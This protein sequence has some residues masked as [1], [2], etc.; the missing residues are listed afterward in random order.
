MPENQAKLDDSLAQHYLAGFTFLR[1]HARTNWWEHGQLAPLAIA[2]A[3]LYVSK[4][5][6]TL[7]LAGTPF[8][9]VA[10]DPELVL[11]DNYR[12]PS[13]REISDGVQRTREL[14]GGCFDEVRR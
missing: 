12:H 5:Y 2:D 6:N 8:A 3:I 11:T 14:D 7:R 4:N 13:D 1:D 9:P 10:A